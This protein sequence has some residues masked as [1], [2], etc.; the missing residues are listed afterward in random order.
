MLS[1]ILGVTYAFQYYYFTERHV[2]AGLVIEVPSPLVNAT[3][4]I[5]PQALNLGSIGKWI[6]AYIE[7]PE[8]YDVSNINVSTI[9]LNG[10]ISAELKPTAIGDYDN[11]TIPDLMVMFDRQR[12]INYI[13]SHVDLARL[14]EE[15][16]M[17]ITLTITGHLYDGTP[18]QGM[19]TVKIIMPTPRG[20][21][22]T[23]PI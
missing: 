3:V 17:E 11:D 1:Y 22:K 7:L 13:M 10:T 14:Y 2:N 18:F 15:G 21:Y 20:L 6:T 9:L 12:V 4:D 5:N 16:F 8:G 19:D 23:F